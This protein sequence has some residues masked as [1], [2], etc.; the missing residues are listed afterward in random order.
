MSDIFREVDEDLRHEQYKRLW[1]RF[2]PYVIGL[3]VLIVAVTAGWRLWEYWQL[4]TAEATGDRFVAALELAETGKREEALAA[5]DQIAADGSGR[6]RVLAD[7]RVAA[8]KEAAGDA[9][10]AVEAFD[11]LAMA[12][13]TPDSIKPIARLRAALILVD[14]AGL[15]DLEDRIG[16]LAATGE[17][18]RHSAREILGL[19]AWRE[20][21]LE[22]ARK[23]YQQI[24]E[25]QEKPADLQTRAEF[26]LALIRARTGDAAPAASTDSGGEG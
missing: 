19:A 2:G 7:F 23:Y 1:D 4:R 6:Y 20:G 11:A 26:M 5:L 16:D 10:G 3:A 24:S 18:W 15:A 12:S 25:D 8:E 17:P 21:D 9:E 22:A 13:G 14:T